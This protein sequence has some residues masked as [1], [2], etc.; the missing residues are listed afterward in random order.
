MTMAS[1]TSQEDRGSA[2]RYYMNKIFGRGVERARA[3]ERNGASGNPLGPVRRVTIEPQANG[4]HRIVVERSAAV[5]ET[6]RPASSDS[7]AGRN[8][9]GAALASE[10]S[11]GGADDAIRFLS[12]VLNGRAPA[13][14]GGASEGD[15]FLGQILNENE[16]E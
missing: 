4:G 14:S 5:E 12:G 16:G 2:G 8:A 9:P 15:R 11:V 10:H 6:A 7:A 1:E 3:L 13:V